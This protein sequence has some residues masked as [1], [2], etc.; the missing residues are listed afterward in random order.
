MSQIFVFPVSVFQVVEFP[1]SMCNGTDSNSQGTCY[2]GDIRP[3]PPKKKHGQNVQ[4]GR[5]LKNKVF[6]T[7]MPYIFPCSRGVRDP[8]RPRIR[9]LRGRVRGLLRL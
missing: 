5:G 9:D 8:R 7:H 2:T 6:F 4:I 1:N 3:P